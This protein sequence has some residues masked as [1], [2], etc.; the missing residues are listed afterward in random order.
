MAGYDTKSIHRTKKRIVFLVVDLSVEDGT[1]FE[2]FPR[3]IV[4]VGIYLHA[5]RVG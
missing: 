5:L 1:C 4:L 2:F 3:M